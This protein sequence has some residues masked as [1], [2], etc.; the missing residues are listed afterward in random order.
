MDLHAI[1]EDASETID[2]VDTDQSG[3]W[4]ASPAAPARNRGI[5][6]DPA[7]PIVPDARVP[8]AQQRSRFAMS[9]LPQTTRAQQIARAMAR[10]SGDDRFCTAIAQA[11]AARDAGD[12]ACAMD[13]YGAALR[14]CPL[15]WGYAIQ[16][17]HMAKE[18][19]LT[20]TA[21]AW[22]RSAVALGAPAD[23]VDQHLAF[24]ARIN[25]VD[26]VR[27]GAPDL[28]VAPMLAPPAV[29]DIRLLGT[30]TRVPGLA[31][32]ALVLD[33]LRTMP[34]NRAVLRHMLAMPE[35][36]RANR[37]LLEILR[38]GHA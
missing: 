4:I 6:P 2:I 9:A 29:H 16:Y 14:A 23:M 1:G 8:V 20:L 18:Q 11:D 17:A 10:A 30:L 22:Y 26:F 7:P 34:D 3:G 5:P 19:G 37:T 33:L 13:H 12:W 21:E 25:G 15:H 32:D 38:A 24:V 36:A 31:D 27:R 35:C 28:D